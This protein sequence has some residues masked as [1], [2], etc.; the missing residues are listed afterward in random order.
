MN[1]VI[2]GA[3]RG[4]G[5]ETAVEC[6]RRGHHVIALS[7]SA[8]G[9][10]KLEEETR[11]IG[12]S[13]KLFISGTDITNEK[14]LQEMIFRI[15]RL[16]DR[17]DV[18]VNNAATF[19]KKPFEKTG[20][21]ELRS[22]YESNVFAV[23]RL[24][25]LLLPMMGGN[26]LSQIVNIGSMGGVRGSKKFAGLAAYSS[27]KSALAGL[28]EIMAEEFAGRNIHVNYLALGSVQTEMFT[29]AFPQIKAASSSSEMA[30]WIV[31]FIVEGGNLINGKIIEVSSGTP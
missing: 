27:S 8:P 3:S 18:L 9:L 24:T 15:S 26:Q 14:E 22:I 19:I 25:Q 12:V 16:H 29:E 1:I 30:K 11:K 17:I 10:E 2:T 21:D 6:C 4:I 13:E 20:L 28:T 31:N 5:F 7:R 23:F